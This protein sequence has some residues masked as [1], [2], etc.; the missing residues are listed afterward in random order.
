MKILQGELTETRYEFPQGDR[1]S[2]KGKKKS[3]EVIAETTYGKNQ[4]AY[5]SDD[6]GVHKVW[7][8]S[9]DIAVSL[10]LY[11]PPNIVKNGCY[12]FE[13]HTGKET[14]I[15]SCEYHSVLGKPVTGELGKPLL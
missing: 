4:V 8:R 1:G 5:M 2:G 14:H 9:E 7:N 13:E 15:Q 6:L 11:T 3:M 12:V 10:H